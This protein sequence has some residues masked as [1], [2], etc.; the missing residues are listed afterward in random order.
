MSPPFSLNNM[1]PAYPQ[2][3]VSVETNCKKQTYKQGLN[4]S[5]EHNTEHLEITFASDSNSSGHKN[6]IH[7]LVVLITLGQLCGP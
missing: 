6:I 7:S 3:Y 1:D 4:Y 5:F 2:A